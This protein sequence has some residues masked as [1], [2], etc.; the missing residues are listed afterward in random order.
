MKLAMAFVLTGVA[1]CSTKDPLY[2]SPDHACSAGLPYCDV[3]A[4]FPSS[5]GIKNTCIEQPYGVS[6]QVQGPGAVSSEPAGI[7]CPGACDQMFE[8]GTVVTLHATPSDGDLFGGWTGDCTGTD[9]ACTVTANATHAVVARFGPPAHYH[10]EVAG[11]GHV[12]SDPAGIDCPGT[13]DAM[14]TPFAHVKLTAMSDTGSAFA[15]W[16]GGCTGANP[17]CETDASGDM[18][19]SA[20]FAKQLNLTIAFVGGGQGHVTSS[21]GLLDCT[22]DCTKVV[23]EGATITLH[24]AGIGDDGFDGWSGPC[25]GEDDC[26]FTMTAATTVTATFRQPWERTIAS[27]QFKDVVADAA[28]NVFAAGGLNAGYGLVAKYDVAGNNPWTA[29]MGTGCGSGV[30]SCLFNSI[31]IDAAGT[32]CAV[33][34]QLQSANGGTDDDWWVGRMLAADGSPGWS[35]T[36][37]NAFGGT[38]EPEGVGIDSKGNIVAAGFETIAAGDHRALV[39]TYDA[40]GTLLWSTSA[41]QASSRAVGVAVDAADVP[42]VAGYDDATA[43]SSWLVTYDASG[44]PAP[45]VPVAIAAQDLALVPG[46]TTAVAGAS[47]QHATLALLDGAG[48]LTWSK[49]DASSDAWHGV[50]VDPSRGIL[51]VAGTN[52]QGTTLDAYDLTGTMVFTTTD[53]AHYAV[54][55]TCDSAHHDVTL[56]G[57]AGANAWIRHYYR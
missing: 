24:Q 8:N 26:T 9:P 42:H 21:D 55:V 38:D 44:T 39:R 19:F 27:A 28:G 10:V 36:Y 46:G 14:F 29:G 51:Y 31:A 6:V 1:A 43:S 57:A 32:H 45:R 3:T 16:T 7:A 35:R 18:T 34:G 30:H 56:A 41:A 33:G 2:C 12:V 22:A 54:A 49:S 47:M 20:K 5:G 4:Q 37:A 13:C 40:T 50:C 23:G 53:L 52:A 15:S 48:A 25:T 17:D 11:G